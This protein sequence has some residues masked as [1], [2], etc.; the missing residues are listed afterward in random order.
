MNASPNAR[1]SSHAP[2]QP[3]AWVEPSRRP[4]QYP[5]R[6]TVAELHR[7]EP[8]ARADDDR[9]ES[10]DSMISSLYEASAV[11]RALEM[12][13]LTPQRLANAADEVARLAQ[14]ADRLVC[15]AILKAGEL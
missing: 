2:E 1:P 9:A 3:P 6:N 13:A 11:L 15:D 4:G 5:W 8:P 14:M 7:P 10:R 12:F